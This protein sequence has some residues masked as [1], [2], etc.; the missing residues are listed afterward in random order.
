MRVN[1]LFKY[2]S[3]EQY[4]LSVYLT[5]TAEE[6]VKPKSSMYLAVENTNEDASVIN[7]KQ[8]KRLA[9]TSLASFIKCDEDNYN[10]LLKCAEDTRLWEEPLS[11]YKP[12][13]TESDDFTFLTLIR[14]EYDEHVFSNM[15]Q[16]FFTHKDYKKLFM[17]YMK[18]KGVELSDTYIVKREEAY[19]DL[20]IIDEN[21][22]I[23]I[24]N[25]VRSGI[26]GL[27]FDESKK[28]VGTQLGKYR[29][30]V[31]KEYNI[32]NPICFIFKPDYSVITENELE[33]Y[34]TIA[35]SELWEIFNEG[36][37]IKS[38]KATEAYFAD[39]VKA[40]KM[41]SS[42]VDNRYEET[43][44]RRLQSVIDSQKND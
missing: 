34:T 43:M 39:F 10:T 44:R 14:K 24:E 8:R 27:V 42:P 6:I 17:N 15:F 7:I 28:V 20:L 13:N 36:L 41:H 2:N 23:I 22:V 12:I 26:N 9:T 32:E 29:E 40:L 35:Y 1:E 33:G 30:Y 3:T 18:K 19:I 31:K 16:Y 37:N 21:N 5:Y 25:K 38:D 4:G 11:Y